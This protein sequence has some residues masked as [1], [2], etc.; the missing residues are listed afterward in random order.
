MTIADNAGPLGYAMRRKSFEAAEHLLRMDVDLGKARLDIVSG[1]SNE[2][3]QKLIDYGA[4]FGDEA[5]FSAAATGA[6]KGA[7]AIVKSDQIV[8]FN[9][10]DELIKRA[11]ERAD[12]FDDDANQASQANFLRTST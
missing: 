2:L 5:V 7:L 6:I 10:Q 3:L 4:T 1:S 8:N 11:N 9:G 12:R